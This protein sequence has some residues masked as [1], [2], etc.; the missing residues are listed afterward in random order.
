MAER[1]VLRIPEIVL[2]WSP[3][4][5]WNAVGKPEGLSIPTRPGVYEVRHV[6]ADQERLHIGKTTSLRRR[7][8]R[9][10]IGGKHSTGRKMRATEDLSRLVV[11]WA[12]TSRPACAEEA[13]RRR[14][15]V[16]FDRLPDYDQLA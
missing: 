9:D 10:M 16:R 11:R 7:I 3:W 12:E 15:R 8:R 14:Y 13:L 4:V 6:G 5:A 1:I 2:K